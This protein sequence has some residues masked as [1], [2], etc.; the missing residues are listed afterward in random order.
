MSSGLQQLLRD[1][2]PYLVDEEAETSLLEEEKAEGTDG[3]P[4]AAQQDDDTIWFRC[5]SR[6]DLFCWI[7]FCVSAELFFPTCYLADMRQLE[8]DLTFL[9][10][11][12]GKPH[13]CLRLG[14]KVL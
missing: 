10:K 4:L 3:S 2:K 12:L 7:L 11:S 1:M 8:A 9:T 5:V 14:F 6:F 13:G